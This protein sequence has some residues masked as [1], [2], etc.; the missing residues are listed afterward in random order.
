MERENQNERRVPRRYRDDI[1]NLMVHYGDLHLLNGKQIV[2]TL[3]DFGKICQRDQ[4]KI[5]AYQGLR[6]YLLKQYGITLVLSS[7][8]TKI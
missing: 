1:S 5:A 7:K 8:K 6:N 3:Q 2:E 4:L